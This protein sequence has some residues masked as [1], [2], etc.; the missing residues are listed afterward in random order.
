[1]AEVDLLSN[2]EIVPMSRRIIVYS[3]GLF[4]CTED[5]ADLG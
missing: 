3:K 5:K 2:S 1:M 4:L